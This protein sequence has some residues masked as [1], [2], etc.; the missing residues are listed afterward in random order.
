MKADAT[1]ILT[2]MKKANQFV[3]PIYQRRYAWGREQCNR[4]W[5]D[6]ENAGMN[7]SVIAHFMGSVVYIDQDINLISHSTPQILIDGQQ[8]LTT[9]TLLLAAIADILGEEKSISGFKSKKIRNY[10]LRNNEEQ[11]DLQY[12]LILSDIDRST[13]ISIINQNSTS[14]DSIRVTSSYEFL[15][16][17]IESCK[18]ADLEIIWKG[19][20]KLKI[21]E[22]GLE[23]GKDNPQ[24]IFECMNSTGRSLSQSDLI[25]NFVLMNLT[26]REQENLYKN[27]W[28]PM[29]D[30]FPQKEYDKNF[31]SFMRHYLTLKT[32]TIPKIGRIYDTFKKCFIE[33]KDNA[34]KLIDDIK[35]YSRYYSA[36]A[37]GKESDP[38]LKILFE[39]IKI[40]NVE[41]SFPLLLKV[42]G[43][44]KK[45]VI[46]KNDIVKIVRTVESYIFR[47]AICGIPTSALN[48]IFPPL[49]NSIMEK[50]E[51]Y[52][53]KINSHL[54]KNKFPSDE[55]FKGDLMREDIYTSLSP[56]RRKYLLDRLENHDRKEDSREYN[57]SIE[58]IMPQKLDAQWKKDL[59]DDYERI[60]DKYL[61]SIGNLTLSGYNSQYSN[62]SFTEK[63]DMNNGFKKSPLHLNE[64]LGDI[65]L[66][67][68]DAIRDRAEKL[69]NLA[70][71][72]WSSIGISDRFSK[73]YRSDNPT[74]KSYS[75]ESFKYLKSNELRILFD[76]IDKEIIN[77]DSSV[78]REFTKRYIAYKADGNF[79][80]IQPMKNSLDLYINMPFDDIQDPN[81]ICEDVS[82]KG[83]LGNGD[84]KVKLKTTDDI[85]CILDL[86]RQSL[87]YQ[88]DDN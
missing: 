25:R 23:R 68:E 41:V 4:L 28:K 54:L 5:E 75:V 70:L 73:K 12:K 67:N 33:H 57:Y 26:Q 85:D 34:E 30:E 11:G 39:R 62:R 86:V 44:Y 43:S 24:L 71:T 48:K 80:D 38:V 31:D 29:E 78:K 83:H 79:V 55:E 65:D 7:S 14:R 61:H 2:F 18:S 27:H 87:E 69:S 8:R 37:L 6:I 60:H 59:G 16:E 19:I 22:I 42:Y 21:V 32:G 52:I 51:G 64:G 84:I 49:I 76:G 46:E 66:W 20:S 15:K 47:R 74:K 17:K 3:V 82:D 58:H 56:A 50:K 40:L 53:E 36:I 45:G 13:L 1:D 88:F 9:I 77:L 63:R 72:V 81:G 10:Y 35:N